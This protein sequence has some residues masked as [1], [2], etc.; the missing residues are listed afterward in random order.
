MKLELK[1]SPWSKFHFHISSFQ[2]I[3]RFQNDTRE[4]DWQYQRHVFESTSER[5]D[6]RS[7]YWRFDSR[8]CTPKAR[9]RCSGQLAQ[10]KVFFIM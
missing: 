2:I 6:H 4:L 5:P 3:L 10:K 1:L 7:R 9:T 8:N